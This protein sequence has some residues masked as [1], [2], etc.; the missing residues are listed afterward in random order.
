[1]KTKER[2]RL[3]VFNTLAKRTLARRTHWPDRQS[4]YASLTGRGTFKGW[5]K[6]AL[7]AYVD[8]GLR[9]ADEDGVQLKCPAWLEA[10]IF[11]S[12]P[13]NLWKLLGQV[14]TPVLFLYGRT[15]YSVVLKF[16]RSVTHILWLNRSKAGIA[17]CSNILKQQRSAP[18][19]FYCSI[20]D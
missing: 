5:T 13:N 1:M 4:A 9:A 3:G 20:T 2:L 8:H 17:L 10:T 15:T 12:A 16:G 19:I 11:S 7:R 6:D 14:Q 18:A